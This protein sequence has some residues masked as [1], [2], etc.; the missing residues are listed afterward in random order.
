[1]IQNEPVDQ[2]NSDDEVLTAME[3]SGITSRLSL[4]SRLSIAK[5]LI[6][7]FSRIKSKKGILDQCWEGAAELGL[8]SLLKSN[9]E[10]DFDSHWVQC[11]RKGCN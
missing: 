10:A 11:N 4:T 1:M 9:P 8:Q 2:L 5:A 3:E 7:H 6:A